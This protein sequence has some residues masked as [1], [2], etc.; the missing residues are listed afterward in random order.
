MNIHRM[1]LRVRRT[2]YGKGIA[3]LHTEGVRRPAGA[4]AFIDA[5]SSRADRGAK[6][7]T[8]FPKTR[9]SR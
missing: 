3:L 7:T 8:A 4:Y 1:T 9:D 5:F 2:A 6:K